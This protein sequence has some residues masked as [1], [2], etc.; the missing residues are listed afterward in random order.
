ME[1]I[2]L[3]NILSRSSVR[4]YIPGFK[5]PASDLTSILKAAMAAPSA[6]N[7]QPW[8]FV[9]VDNPEIL[10]N[11]A[12]SLPYAK[13]T[14]GASVAIVTCGDESRFLEGIDNSLWIQDLSAVN[15]NIL[16]AAHA[17][18]YGGVWTCVYPHPERIAPVADILGL[19]AGI[20]PFAVIPIGRPAHE[21]HHID[22]WDISKI[23]VNGWSGKYAR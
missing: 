7:R 17:I 16:L 14:A 1:N 23:H 6:V 2:A 20:I 11:L 3:L 19:P 21:P 10:K 4:T 9:V 22:K 8:Q 12:D 18:G 13:M 15:E 5:I